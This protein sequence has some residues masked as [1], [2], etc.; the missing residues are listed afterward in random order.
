MKSTGF[1]VKSAGFHEICR[2]SK[3]EL[4]RDDQ[5]QVFLSKDQQ[6][7]ISLN[8][9]V[10]WAINCIVSLECK[11]NLVIT[12]TKSFYAAFSKFLKAR[13]KLITYGYS[14]NKHVAVGNIRDD[15]N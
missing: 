15:T 14:I 2:I 3:Y 9:F 5:V 11:A 13:C 6:A 8:W 10:I 12:N 7:S 1:Q 4:L